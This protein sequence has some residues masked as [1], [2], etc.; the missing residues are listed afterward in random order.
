MVVFRARVAAIVSA[1]DAQAAR[2]AG[3]APRRNRDAEAI[4]DC[5]DILAVQRRKRDAPGRQF[6]QGCRDR[7]YGG[8]A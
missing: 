5:E 1:G 7:L 6:K 8:A 4:Q 2:R 3:L